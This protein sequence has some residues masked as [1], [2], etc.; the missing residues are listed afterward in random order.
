MRDEGL[1]SVCDCDC[2]CDCND[3]D[4]AVNIDKHNFVH[5]H[6]SQ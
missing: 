6:I 1:H 2:D 5:K 4:D 3:T